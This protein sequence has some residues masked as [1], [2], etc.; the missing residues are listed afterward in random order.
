MTDN[1]SRMVGEVRQGVD[2]IATASTQI[3]QGNSDLSARTEQQASSLEETAA[4][5]EEM[6]KHRAQFGRQCAPGQSTRFVHVRCGRARWR[7]GLASRCDHGR[8]PGREP[9]HRRHHRRH[10]RH[11][12]PDPTSSRST[13][14]SKP[15]APVNKAAALPWSRAKCATL[16]NAVP[17]PRVKFKG[18]IGDSVAKVETGNHIVATAGSTI[19]DVVTQVRRVADLIAEVTSSATEQSQGVEQVNQGRH[20]A[21]SGHATKRGLGGGDRGRHR[22]PARP[23][24]KAR[25]G[26]VGV[27]SLSKV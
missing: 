9:P 17:L 23:G 3:A 13:R 25:A 21:R 16:R 15:L 4:S 8:N 2:A 14:R 26:G 24:A 1:L 22:Q 12:L 19:E 7:G 6:G 18:L 10:R 5:M 20:A 27:Q 11:R